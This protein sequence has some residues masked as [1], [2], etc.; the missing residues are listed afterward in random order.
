MYK[1]NKF[2]SKPAPTIISADGEF[3]TLKKKLEKILDFT[4]GWTGYASLGHNN[5]SILRAI[6]NQMTKFCH[7]DYNE[8]E[9]PLIESLSKKIIDFAPNN[10]KKIWYSGNSGSEAN[11]STMK[12]SY[13][14][15]YAQGNKKKIKFIHRSQSFHGA[16]LHPL[17][18]TSI[19]IFKIFKKLKIILYKYLRT[20]FLQIIILKPI[21]VKN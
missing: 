12:L 1:F 18:V 5:K 20:I 9:N 14:V 17:G 4:S 6:K 2:R 19:D 10:S 15:H 11:R 21:W 8:F 7:V 3:L 13:Q 16:T